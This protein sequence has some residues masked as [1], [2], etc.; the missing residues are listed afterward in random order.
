MLDLK[1]N[2]DGSPHR[3]SW[4]LTINVPTL[5]A[6]VGMIGG[7]IIF[8]VNKYSDVNDIVKGNAYTNSTQDRAIERLDLETK[9][10]RNE[11]SSKLD[12]LRGEMRGELRDVN[13]KLD[14]LLL[15]GRR[16]GD[17]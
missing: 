13:G 9:A 15:Q 3:V 8:G 4:D 17:S 11:Q 12:A 16:G 2:E 1:K 10:L 5:I 6:M 14:Q 7:S